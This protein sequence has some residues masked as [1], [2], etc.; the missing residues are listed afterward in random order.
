MI[1]INKIYIILVIMTSAFY[2]HTLLFIPPLPVQVVNVVSIFG[3][4][5][6]VYLQSM[7]TANW[8]Q[9]SVIFIL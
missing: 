7:P 4:D 5:K 9:V 6:K 2:S 3:N 8:P 1:L